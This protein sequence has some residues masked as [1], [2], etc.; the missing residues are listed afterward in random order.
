MTWL[1]AG[2]LVAGCG[3]DD[4]SGTSSDE[5]T[6]EPTT[7]SFAGEYETAVTLVGSTCPDITVMDNPTFV[8][9]GEEDGSITMKHADVTF[10]ATIND[11]GTFIGG[12]QEV[13]VGEDTHTLAIE[14]SFSGNALQAS[15]HAEVT[16]SQTCGYDRGLGRGPGVNHL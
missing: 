10:S 4:S 15:I 9:L 2:L 12:P 7:E 8:D 13:Q 6:Q 5:P 11:T 16:G 3:G 14:G 1:L